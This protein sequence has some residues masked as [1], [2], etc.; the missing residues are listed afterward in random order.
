MQDSAKHRPDFPAAVPEKQNLGRVEGENRKAEYADA[1]RGAQTAPKVFGVIRR[2][3]SLQRYL[4]RAGKPVYRLP[5]QFFC[6]ERVEIG[7]SN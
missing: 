7:D 3:S 4:P 6:K 1:V 2:L 5:L